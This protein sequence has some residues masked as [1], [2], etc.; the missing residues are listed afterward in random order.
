MQPAPDP[1]Q[2]IYADV[3]SLICQF[4][5]GRQDRPDVVGDVKVRDGFCGETASGDTEVV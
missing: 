4:G 3:L 2:V 5:D 1:C